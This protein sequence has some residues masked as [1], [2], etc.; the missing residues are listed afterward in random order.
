MGPM[1]GVVVDISV[2]TTVVD[3]YEF[4]DMIVVSTVVATDVAVAVVLV[5]AGVVGALLL[6]DEDVEEVEG[7]VGDVVVGTA[8]TDVG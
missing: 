6:L 2:V 8:V 1:T 5:V 4:V 3:P 7:V